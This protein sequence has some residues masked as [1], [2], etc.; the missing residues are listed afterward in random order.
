[1]TTDSAQLSRTEVLV[2]GYQVLEGI[3]LALDQ[4][5]AELEKCIGK[6][7]CIERCG[8]CCTHYTPIA[9]KLEALRITQSLIHDKRLAGYCLDWLD[10]E[11]RGME[12]GCPFLSRATKGC[13]IYADRPIICRAYGV[14]TYSEICPR[15]LHTSETPTRRM[16]VDHDTRLGKIIRGALTE[17]SQKLAASP[18]SDLGRV[19]FLPTLFARETSPE[20]MGRLKIDHT[21][22]ISGDA[23]GGIFLGRPEP[24][25]AI[26]SLK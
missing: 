7:I 15:P 6:P 21:K 3:Y 12:M 5:R 20:E 24:W 11:G 17:L 23:V 26:A 9:M 22:L 19:G 18:H 10:G 2:Q 25:A 8:K 13:V 4:G 16:A 1:M 14:T